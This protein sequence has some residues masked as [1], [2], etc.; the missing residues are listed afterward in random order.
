M[1]NLNDKY[2]KFYFP[3]DGYYLPV[4]YTVLDPKHRQ[5]PTG[6]LK[7]MLDQPIAAI[8]LD[9]LGPDFGHHIEARTMELDA[10]QLTFRC[11]AVVFQAKE[12]LAMPHI[13]KDLLEM[14]HR[15]KHC[16]RNLIKTLTKNVKALDDQQFK[17]DIRSVVGAMRGTLN[18]DLD[19]DVIV[20]M[21][22]MIND[23]PPFCPL[24][25]ARP[26]ILPSLADFDNASEQ[27]P[28]EH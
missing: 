20:C 24:A 18:Q 11:L 13:L 5:I 19:P 8:V 27:T 28:V 14:V 7:T 6:K 16:W 9:L 15:S 21:Q 25:A 4:G 22:S 26:S 2:E 23:F 1:D 17:A 10:I 3:V 12:D